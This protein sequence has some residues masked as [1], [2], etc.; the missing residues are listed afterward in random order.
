MK[1]DTI[2]KTI[3]FPIMSSPSKFLL[4]MEP[5]EADSSSMS[6]TNGET[7]KTWFVFFFAWEERITKDYYIETKIVKSK[8]C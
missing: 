1:R 4:K 8:S 2:A 5:L 7:L 3:T 6:L